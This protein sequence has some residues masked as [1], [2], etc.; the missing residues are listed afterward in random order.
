MTA[1]SGIRHK[2]VFSKACS[3]CGGR[4]DMHHSGSICLPRTK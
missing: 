3:G 2:G 4:F 1:A